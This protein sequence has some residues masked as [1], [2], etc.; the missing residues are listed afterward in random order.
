VRAL[1]LLAGLQKSSP[2]PG[3]LSPDEEHLLADAVAGKLDRWS[4]SDA[5]LLASGVTDAARRKEYLCRLDALEADMRKATGG[6]G[7]QFEKGQQLLKFLH[8]GPMAKG[9]E[10]EQSNLSTLLDTGKFNCISSAT[11]YN[12]LARRLG[13]DVRAVAIPN[14]VFATLHDGS[15]CAP[16]E[17]TNASGF[18][19]RKEH[20]G[21][22]REVGQWGL[23]AIIYCNR[24]VQRSKEKRPHEA[25]VAYGCALILDAGNASAAKNLL[26]EL[27]NWSVGLTREGKYPEALAVLERGLALQPGDGRWTNQVAYLAQ[28]WAR[29]VHDTQGPQEAAALLLRLQERFR[30]QKAIREEVNSVAVNH[31]RRVVHRHV[32]ARRYTDARTS[33]TRYAALLSGKGEAR[34][35][36]VG[37]YDAEAREL[38]EAGH[39]QGAVKVYVQALETYRQDGHLTNNLRATC[40][41]AARPHINVGH[42]NEAIA[43]YEEGLKVLPSDPHLTHNLDYCKQQRAK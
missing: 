31:V 18:D 13:L 28:E 21:P 35:L 19:R 15:R 23:V 11:L 37:V 43:V 20:G 8:E 39:W 26:A 29:A 7:T 40:D 34:D 1:D 32:E 16:V 33:I 25:V 10:R 9:Y 6:A 42:W 4:F 5:A 14:H 2:L 24:G 36:A 41:L 17:T 22:R 3:V 27:N 12:V 30:L 38:Q